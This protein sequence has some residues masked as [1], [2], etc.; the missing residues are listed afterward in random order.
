MQS[1][2]SAISTGQR[3]RLKTLSLGLLNLN[4]FLNFTSNDEP[5]RT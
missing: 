1:L 3:L 2:I 5:T 4:V